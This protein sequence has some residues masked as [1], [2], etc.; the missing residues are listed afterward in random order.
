MKKY[1]ILSLL[2]VFIISSCSKDYLDTKPTDKVDGESVFNTVENASKL[3]NGIYRLMFE[4]TEEVTSNQQNKPG[5]GGILLNIDFMGEDLGISNNNWFSSE[6]SWNAHRVDNNIVP[7]YVYRTFYR[8]I[9]NANYIIDNVD[10]AVGT[11]SEK[12]RVKS[13]AITLRAYAYSYLVQFFGKRYDANA[14]PNSQAGVPLPLS[15]KDN[16]MPRA[17]VEE[18]YAAIVKDLED[19]I[20]LNVTTRTNKSHANALVAKALRARV[21]LTMQDYP[22]AIK[23]AK[24]V[25]DAGEFPLMSEAA[26]L[27][28][29]NNAPNLSEVMWASMPTEDQGDTFGSF[30]GQIAYNANTSFMRANPKRIN[31]ALY[32][33][34]AATDVRKKLWE[35][36][37]TADNFSLPSTAFARQPYMSRKFAVKVVGGPSLGDVPL[38]RSA[39]MYLILAEA[40]ARNGQEGEAQNTLFQLTSV[41]DANAIKSTNSGAA[42]IEEVLFNRRIELWGEGFRW[43]DLKRLNLPLNRT[44]VPNFVSASVAGVM[45]IPAGDVRWQFLIPRSEMEANPNIGEQNP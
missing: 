24:E 33:Q 45:E 1:L 44:V 4:R 11:E 35:P 26:Y 36:T 21:A 17:T 5:V 40:Y 23:Y 13:E 28:G 42:L 2:F 22:N 15:T 41:R 19:V 43:L 32:S 6:A 20:A 14:K 39:E 30:F 25:I 10:A 3:L 27:S 38:L 8:I 12:A 16:D 29:F 34:I 31:S 7:Q 37:P 9:G 18:V